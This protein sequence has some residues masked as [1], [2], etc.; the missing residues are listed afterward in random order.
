MTG[1]FYFSEYS[2]FYNFLHTFST[3]KLMK[4]FP[5]QAQ[6][7]QIKKILPLYYLTKQ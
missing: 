5:F 3:Y 1:F 6:I 4:K 2:Y 7:M